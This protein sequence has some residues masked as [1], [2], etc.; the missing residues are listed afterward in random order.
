[1]HIAHIFNRSVHVDRIT[2]TLIRQ[3]DLNLRKCMPR[4]NNTNHMIF[5]LLFYTNVFFSLSLSQ[6][7]GVAFSYVIWRIRVINCVE[8]AFRRV[9]IGLTQLVFARPLPAP[10]REK[11]NKFHKCVICIALTQY[12][13]ICRNVTIVVKQRDE[14][15]N[16]NC[17][18]CHLSTFPK[19]VICKNKQRIANSARLPM[20][21]KL[22]FD[23]YLYTAVS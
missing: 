20:M 14:M 19:C 11:T 23:S 2:M 16:A 12:K 9:W 21:R 10:I 4:N 1:M 7:I 18:S 3:Q 6:P 15:D 17:I 22:H 5:L 13:C 8:M